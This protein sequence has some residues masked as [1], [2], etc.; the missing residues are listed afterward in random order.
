MTR[1]IERR[2]MD[3]A[4]RLDLD[5][6]EGSGMERVTNDE[7]LAGRGWDL[8]FWVCLDDV[9]VRDSLAVVGHRW[10]NALGAGWEI[11]R[12]EPSVTGDDGETEDAEA[13]TRWGGRVY[14]FGSHF[15]S[16]DGPIQ[17]ERAFIA[18]IPEGEVRWDDGDP[19]STM[20]VIRDDLALHRIVN[21]GLADADVE[22]VE[23]GPAGRAAFID[24]TREAHPDASWV[25]DLRDED[26]PI[27][28]EGAA[29]RAD[30]SVLLGLRYPTTADGR[31]I[32][33]QLRG[34]QRWFDDR[35]AEP[36]LVGAWIVD[37]VGRDGSMAG[38]RDLTILGRELHV[39]TGNID[40]RE[41][42]SV[43]LEDHPEG[44]D[45]VST[46]WRCDLPWDRA[47]GEVDAEPVAEFPDMPRIEGIATDPEGRFYYVSDEDEEVH[48]RY[49]RFLTPGS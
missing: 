26:R 37:A 49:T 2:E 14:V 11:D 5:P 4:L 12:L 18:R 27:N 1:G 7:L 23:L 19:V 33:V 9:P 15:G 10:G 20:Q 42:G 17:P 36:A 28:I 30:G 40:S 31:P 32:V 47:G 41:K 43:L 25:G 24:G 22:L 45:T 48:V 35:D 6:N 46:H 8:A 21:D 44:R 16:K 34:V 29:F 13:V 39:V 38:V 3:D